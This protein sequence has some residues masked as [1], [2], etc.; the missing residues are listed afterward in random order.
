MYHKFMLLGK[1]FQKPQSHTT[2][3]VSL[4]LNH[5][6]ASSL[7]QGSSLASLGARVQSL[8]GLKLYLFCLMAEDVV[9][10][11]KGRFGRFSNVV[12]FQMLMKLQRRKLRTFSFNT[13]GHCWQLIQ[14][15]A[16]PRNSVVQALVLATKSHTVKRYFIII[17]YKLNLC[18]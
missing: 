3:S 7:Y 5:Y 15:V 14:D 11:K 18:I 2:K 13:T 17:P 1:P 6:F 12:L 4:C 16:N 8:M 10:I 9:A